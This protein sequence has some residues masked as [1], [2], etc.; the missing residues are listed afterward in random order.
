MERK[1]K[2]KILPVL[3]IAL[4][5]LFWECWN[6]Q[7]YM[8]TG[9][10]SADMG[11]Y[12]NGFSKPDK[13]CLGWIFIH[14][15]VQF[16]LIVKQAEFMRRFAVLWYFRN[17]DLRTA[18]L[19]FYGLYWKAPFFY[20]FGGFAVIYLR[21]LLFR[22]TD[23]LW[24]SAFVCCVFYSLVLTSAVMAVCAW[25]FICFLIFMNYQAAFSLVVLGE[26]MTVLYCGR[27]LEGG[28]SFYKY[29]YV[30]FS[31]MLPGQGASTYIWDTVVFCTEILKTAA[32][33]GVA[34]WLFGRKYGT[35]MGMD[36]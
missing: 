31:G 24:G 6:R 18:F 34:V 26:V 28:A 17:R 22:E 5:F 13:R 25:I 11:N 29:R 16:Y 27:A 4:L 15:P 2:L 36:E 35:V 3:A 21:K 7:I 32:V 20:Y 1:L 8:K 14:M 10:F 23:F 9:S 19:G 33:M 12:L 30:P